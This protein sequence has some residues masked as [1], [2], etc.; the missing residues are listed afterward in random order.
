MDLVQNN[1]SNIDGMV[2][3]FL[4]SLKYNMIELI[5]NICYEWKWI[6][7]FNDIDIKHK[8]KMLSL[9]HNIIIVIG[10]N[11]YNVYE[12]LINK[13]NESETWEN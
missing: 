9:S 10:D 5:Y 7:K 8:N 6:D 13:L 4:T 3:V 11:E 12:T 2:N 1:I